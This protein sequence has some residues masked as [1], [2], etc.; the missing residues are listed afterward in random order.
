MLL[1]ALAAVN[2]SVIAGLERNLRGFSTFR[3]NCIKHFTLAATLILAGSTA[4][5]AA[6]GFVLESFFRVELLF[7]G[8]KDELRTAILAHQHFVFEHVSFPSCACQADDSQY[9]AVSDLVFTPTP[10]NWKV[11]S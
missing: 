5:F 2:G 4:G 10:A 9:P 11:R 7:T 3:A 6:Y 8:G 1:K